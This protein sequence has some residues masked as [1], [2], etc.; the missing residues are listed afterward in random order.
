MTAVPSNVVGT[1]GRYLTVGGKLKAVE[2][3]WQPLF[4]VLIEF[5]SLSGHMAGMIPRSTAN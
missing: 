2:G 4:P 5:P 3:D 1:R